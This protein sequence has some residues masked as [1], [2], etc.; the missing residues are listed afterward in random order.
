V[1]EC[2]LFKKKEEIGKMSQEIL[3]FI[4]KENFSNQ[5]KTD[6]KKKMVQIL[7]IL[8]ILATYGKPAL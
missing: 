2:Y 1:K 5:D 6:V 7:A 8:H 4:N 3:E